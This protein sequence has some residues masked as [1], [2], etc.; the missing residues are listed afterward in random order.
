MNYEHPISQ[1]WQLAQGGHGI[2]QGADDIDLC[3]H[4]ILSTRKGADVLRPDFGSNHFDYL[5]TP[6]DIFVPNVVREITL[7]IQTWE[8]RA[9]VER[10]R[11]SGN[12]PRITMIVEWRIADDIVSEL[13]QTQIYATGTAT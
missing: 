8:K 3:I 9:V 2:T 10:V 13:Y 7:A 4:N 1:H 11:F 6:E 5:D 12:A